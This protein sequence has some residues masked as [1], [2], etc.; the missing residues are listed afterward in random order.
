MEEDHGQSHFSIIVNNQGNI[1]LVAC[2]DYR[3]EH[4]LQ[5]SV[6]V[7]IDHLSSNSIYQR[8]NLLL[9]YVETNKTKESYLLNGCSIYLTDEPCV[10]CAMALLH[11]RIENVFYLNSNPTFGSLGSIYKLHL[12]KKT[13]HRFNVYQL[14]QIENT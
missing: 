3:C 5:H 12:L 11:S 14:K 1:P 13:N 4:P 7:A 6:M 8:E 9:K 2:K 10:M